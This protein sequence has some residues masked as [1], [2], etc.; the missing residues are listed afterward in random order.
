MKASRTG[1]LGY[2][3][4]TSVNLFSHCR[5]FTGAE[6]ARIIEL[7]DSRMPQAQ[8]TRVLKRSARSVYS[9]VA[10][11]R[12]RGMI[13]QP[14]PTASPAPPPQKQPA[15][16]A[17]VTSTDTLS[18]TVTKDAQQAV[19]SSSNPT[20]VPASSTVASSSQAPVD[21]RQNGP[22]SL[23]VITAASQNG[24]DKKATAPSEFTPARTFSNG[25]ERAC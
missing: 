15:L 25:V 9:R 1:P 22:D 10:F 6:D 4:L 24:S 7:F 16:G 12:Q 19:A 5:P 3:Q 21:G 18:A 11:L 23:K 14:L 13:S 20:M 2:G 8:I 17:S